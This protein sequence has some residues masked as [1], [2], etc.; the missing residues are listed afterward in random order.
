[1]FAM[2]GGMWGGTRDAVPQMQELIGRQLNASR[3]RACMMST[4]VHHCL[5]V[6]LCL[7]VIDIINV[8]L[9]VCLSLL[10]CACVRA[11]V[12]VYA[13][14]REDTDGMR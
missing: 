8:C 2:S 12:C 4:L 13:T 10:L 9:S 14:L 1:M 11:F 5:S 7:S 6:C 3:E